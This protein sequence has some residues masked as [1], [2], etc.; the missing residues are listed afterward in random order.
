MKTFFCIALTFIWC[1]F[2]SQNRKDIQSIIDSSRIQFTDIQNQYYDLVS[3]TNTLI[4][5][6]EDYSYYSKLIY[7]S[8]VKNNL[9]ESIVLEKSI[10][11]I[12]A[13]KNEYY[14]VKMSGLTVDYEFYKYKGNQ[15]I[16]IERQNQFLENY[17]KDDF[18][19]LTTY[20]YCGKSNCI[21]KY[22][23]VKFTKLD[24]QK[25]L[26]DVLYS[27]RVDR[28]GGVYE[29]FYDTDFPVDEKMLLETF[30]SKYI[31]QS[32]SLMKG[33]KY[34]RDHGSPSKEF[35]SK[36]L[37]YEISWM[38]PFIT[39]KR[40]AL[41]GFYDGK[42]YMLKHNAEAGVGVI[43]TYDNSNKPYYRL[44]FNRNLRYWEFKIDP[45]T[46]DIKKIDYNLVY[47]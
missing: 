10:L 28:L 18:N 41:A 2:Y 26:S 14:K 20:I 29:Q 30:P 7:D 5:K 33:I 17:S 21:N 15:L 37:E 24:S 23:F 38:K 47:E 43:K 3:K 11:K 25:H 4:Y 45:T 19:A 13:D 39:E 16:S 32:L 40:K 27:M 1:F 46:G 6:Q 35:D 22:Q 34:S 44:I 9:P 36:D 12:S 8:L 42:D 31:R